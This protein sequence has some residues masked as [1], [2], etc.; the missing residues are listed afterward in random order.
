MSE[1]MRES[2]LRYEKEW[3][4]RKMQTHIRKA[5]A[6]ALRSPTKGLNRLMLENN[7][8]DLRLIANELD[9]RKSAALTAGK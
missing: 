6:Y 1:A 2:E 9:R 8:R 4:L 7:E 3:R 5:Q